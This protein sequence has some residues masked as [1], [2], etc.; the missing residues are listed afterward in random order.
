LKQSVDIP[1]HL[2]SGIELP[3][4][5]HW[6]AHVEEPISRACRLAANPLLILKSFRYAGRADDEIPNQIATSLDAQPQKVVDTQMEPRVGVGRVHSPNSRP[7][8]VYAKIDAVRGLNNHVR[9]ELVASATNASELLVI[10][11]GY[12]GNIRSMG[13]ELLPGSWVLDRCQRSTNC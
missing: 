11:H 6:H 2:S 9:E 7:I 10:V 5:G 13:P 8:V 1:K 12:A 4:G 3:D